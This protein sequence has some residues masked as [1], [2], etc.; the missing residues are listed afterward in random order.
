MRT[1][2]TFLSVLLGACVSLPHAQ[3]YSKYDEATKQIEAAPSCT[4]ICWVMTARN[5]NYNEARA[6]VNG[7]RVA[8]LPGL[9]AN[10]VR[11]PISRSML[12]A[13]G[14]MVVFVQLY[15]DT[16][17]AYSAKECPVPG[18]RLELAVAESSAGDPLHLY[19]QQWRIK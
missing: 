7:R 3:R 11:I 2:I 19:L 8:T 18:S 15:P 13:A 17:R 5:D 9:M 6:Y 1:H 16:K 10:A 12:D 14:C 4:D